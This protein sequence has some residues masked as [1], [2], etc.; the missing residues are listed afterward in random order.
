MTFFG[1]TLYIVYTADIYRDGHVEYNMQ[2]STQITN[3]S[4]LQFF[5]LYFKGKS[6]NRLGVQVCASVCQECRVGYDIF[7]E[8]HRV[9]E[10]V[11][12]LQSICTVSVN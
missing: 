9:A 1:D 12:P 7:E 4:L 8:T 11:V 2:Q 5:L 10:K 3:I 6:E